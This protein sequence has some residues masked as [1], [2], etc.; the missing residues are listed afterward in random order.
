MANLFALAH[1]RSIDTQRLLLRPVCLADAVDMFEYASDAET[2]RFVFD[3]HQTLDE[4]KETISHFFMKE[5]LGKY[6]IELKEESK[7]IGTIDIRPDFTHKKSELGYILNRHYWGK[8]YMTEAAESLVAL[9]FNELGM[10]KVL[11]M[12]DL[13]NPASARVMLRLGMQH[14]GVLRHHQFHK[15]EFVDMAIYGILKEEYLRNQRL[16]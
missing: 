8:G 5:P 3:Q 13:R 14:E 10:E 4:T 11:A 16:D 9:A 12:H 1:N 7:M 6:A 15:G 2:V